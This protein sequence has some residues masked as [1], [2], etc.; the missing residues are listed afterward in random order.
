[1]PSPCYPTASPRK[2]S[3]RC[4]TPR[5]AASLMVKYNAAD[6]KFLIARWET[7]PAGCIRLRSIRRPSH[8]VPQILRG[9][10]L[11]RQGHWPRAY[12]DSPGGSRGRAPAQGSAAHDALHES[13]RF[14]STNPL[15]SPRARA[16]ARHRTAS[17]IPTCSCRGRSSAT[18]EFDPGRKEK[19]MAKKYTAKCACGAVKFE[20][21][22]GP[23][24]HRRL[25]LPG[26]QAGV[27]RRGSH[28][29]RRAGG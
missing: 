4:S 24:L 5:R 25:P 16:F 19:R 15:A 12:A 26:L 11:P 20:F 1:M 28:I 8:G 6:A 3:W 13:T 14:R 9:R 10:P 21:D 29:L 2:K 7:A 17:A 18:K 22:H 23:R 27:G